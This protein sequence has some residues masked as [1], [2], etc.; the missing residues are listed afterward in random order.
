LIINAS[1]RSVTSFPTLFIV[2]CVLLAAS[3][4]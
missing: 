1:E 4:R 3:E 2:Y